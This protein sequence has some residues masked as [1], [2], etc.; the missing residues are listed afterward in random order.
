MS[1]IIQNNRIFTD[2]D[3]KI[4][5]LYIAKIFKKRHKDVLRGIRNVIANNSGLSDEFKHRNFKESTYINSQ[6][7]KQPCYLLTQDGFTLI[8]LG[9]IGKKVRRTKELYIQELN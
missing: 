4:D 8:A 1:E 7:K 3:N 2:K 5:S 6:N 9:Y